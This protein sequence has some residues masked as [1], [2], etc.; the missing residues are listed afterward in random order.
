MPK[1]EDI[2]GNG[3]LNLTRTDVELLAFVLNN[4]RLGIYSDTQ[5]ERLPTVA[6]KLAAF[7]AEGERPY[8]YVRKTEPKPKKKLVG[9]ALTRAPGSEWHKFKESLGPLDSDVA[10][11]PI[12]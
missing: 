2:A 7:L 5:K 6:R 3:Q 12:E 11:S 4:S 10:N 8:T 9:F 1:A